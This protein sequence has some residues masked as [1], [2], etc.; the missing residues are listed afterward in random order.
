MYIERYYD[1]LA[2]LQKKS[3][4]MLGPRQTGKSCLIRHV[5]NKY[6]VYNKWS[7]K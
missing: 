1:V 3:V 6:K 2:D 5:L 4:L 7:N